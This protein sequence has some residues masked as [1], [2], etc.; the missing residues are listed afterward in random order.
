MLNVH[1]AT[2]LTFSG[3]SDLQDAR[4]FSKKLLEKTTS[5]GTRNQTHVIHFQLQSGNSVILLIIY[6]IIMKTL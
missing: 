1:R 6:F 3:E 4:S 5:I 2:D